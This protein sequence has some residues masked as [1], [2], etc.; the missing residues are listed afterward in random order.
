AKAQADL[1]TAS[2]RPPSAERE[3]QS[4]EGAPRSALCAPTP[5]GAPR[6]ALRA[7]LSHAYFRS[8]AEVLADA[9]EAIHHAH[10]VHILHRDVKP[11]NIMVD[12]AGQCW[13]I[14]FGLAGLVQGRDGEDQKSR[15]DDGGSRIEDP[16]TDQSS[17]L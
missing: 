3:A 1:L 2:F 14:D 11:S 12:T 4:A 10:G 17:I 8:V 16:R 6:S 5:P 9:A 15:I 7:S 13:I